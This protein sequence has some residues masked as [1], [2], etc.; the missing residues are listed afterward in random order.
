[1][2]ITR[3]GAGKLWGLIFR[4]DRLQALREFYNLE[5]YIITTTDPNEYE[6]PA[7]KKER[8]RAIEFLELWTK[9]LKGNYNG[10]TT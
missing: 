1:M 6:A 3:Q 2:K 10:E 9:A 8:L 4:D 7:H 5:R